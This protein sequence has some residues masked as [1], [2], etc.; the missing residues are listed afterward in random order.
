MFKLSGTYDAKA[1]GFRPGG[2]SLH[3]TMSAHGPDAA[4]HRAATEAELAPVRYRDT[5]LAFMFE[6]TF[7][8]RVTPFALANLQQADYYECW[9]G[10]ERHFDP[11]RA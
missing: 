1:A 5:D 3:N 11:E 6:S 7:T 10:L 2:G 4:T 8:F 9:A